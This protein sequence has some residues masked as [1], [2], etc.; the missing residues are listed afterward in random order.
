MNGAKSEKIQT[1]LKKARA[2]LLSTEWMALLFCAA[3]VFSTLTEFFPGERIDIHGTFVFGFITVICLM[4]SDD[5]MAGLAP[6]MATVLVAIKC[7]DSFDVFMEYKPLAVPIIAGLLFHFIVYRKKVIIGGTLFW[8]SVFV[9]AAIMLGGIGFITGEEYFAGTSLYHMI[10]LGA[11]MLLLYIFFYSK[12]TVR[13]E[14]SLIDMLTKIMVFAGAFASFTVI[15]Y[16]LINLNKVLDTRAL[17]FMQWRNNLS[18][19]LMLCMP[20]AFFMA[21][22]RPYAV[23]LG[24]VFWFAILLTGSRGG[25]VFGSVE[26]VMSIVMY[27]LYDKRRRAAYVI[28]CVCFVFAFM[29]FSRQFVSFFGSTIDRLFKAINDFMIGE[30]SETRISHYARGI[31]DFLNHPIFGT[32]L[33]YMGNHDVYASKK[34]AV[35]WY[36]CEPIQVAASFGTIGIA[37]FVYQFIRRNVLLWR[38][39]TLFNMTVFISYMSLEMMSLVNPGIFCPLPYLLLVTMFFV[40]VEKCNEGEYQEEIIV[41]RKHKT[42][43]KN[44][45]L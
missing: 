41:G 25:L 19:I 22:K 43:T 36:H 33:G 14:Y 35:C 18:T 44:V 21:N 10:G 34:G 12:I 16:Y 30:E 4:I 8:P 3:G 38:K 9:S 5:V 24:F 15:T 1:V 13:R 26:L 23:V 45:H 6:F 11:G 39:A 29:A 27:M 17:L 32:G 40:I 31:N 7:Y 2:F 20:F 42:K 28:I 37:A